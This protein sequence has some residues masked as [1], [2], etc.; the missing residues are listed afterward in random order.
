M[1]YIEFK[2]TL[3]K[4]NLKP[5]GK[6]EIV[7]EVTDS[8]L[9]GKLDVLS[10]MI[11]TKVCISLESMQVNFNVTVNAKTNEPVTQY[12][13]DDNGFVKEVKASFEQL[14]ADFDIPEEKIPTREEK[15][16]ADR[17][18]VDAFIIS[19]L[20]PGLDDLPHDFAYIVKRKLEGESYLKLANELKI[21]NVKLIE[22]IDDYRARIAPMAIKWHEWKEKQPDVGEQSKVEEKP[23]EE[24]ETEETVVT[25][26]EQVQEKELQ[27]SEEM[28]VTDEDKPFDETLED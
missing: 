22:M 8:S 3:K 24:T 13:V 23:K 5:D 1:S 25:E 10:E 7:L 4:V 16:Q 28:E 6:K 21:S 11:D 17:E 12:E 26:E 20:A 14:E 15:E 2:P 18:I 27:S 19:G 9:R